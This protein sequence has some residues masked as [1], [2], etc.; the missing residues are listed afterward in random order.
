MEE[1]TFDLSTP[2]TIKPGE[3][4]EVQCIFYK[5]TV[6]KEI[7]LNRD[8]TELESE[9]T[10]YYVGSVVK[11]EEPEETKDTVTASI[12]EAGYVS[13][14]NYELTGKIKIKNNK[15]HMV[16]PQEIRFWV[17]T[18]QGKKIHSTEIYIANDVAL[19]SGETIILPFTITASD[20]PDNIEEIADFDY[21]LADYDIKIKE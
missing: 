20:A 1:T 12:V 15:D 11:G 18:P 2:I 14:Q 3:T 5:E 8:D 17:K 21:L 16:I 10:V 4:A 7:A 6:Y 19:K 13:C 9:A